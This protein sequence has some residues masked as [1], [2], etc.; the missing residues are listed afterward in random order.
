MALEFS[1]D[2]KTS[3]DPPFQYRFLRGCQFSISYSYELNIDICI[4]RILVVL[5][6]V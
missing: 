1:H 6:H 3:V 2:I 5:L 4:F